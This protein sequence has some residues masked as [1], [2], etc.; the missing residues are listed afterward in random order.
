MLRIGFCLGVGMDLKFAIP[1]V[2]A[3]SLTLHFLQEGQILDQRLC[4]L[5]NLSL[6]WVPSLVTGNGHFKLHIL[7]ARVLAK[8]T[9]IDFLVSGTW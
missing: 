1:S 8:V 9:H 5:V 4:K 6:H 3:L 2:S 7:T